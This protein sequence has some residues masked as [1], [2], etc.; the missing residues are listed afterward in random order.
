M[1]RSLS[2]NLF[3]NIVK[4]HLDSEVNYVQRAFN[5]TFCWSNWS[6]Y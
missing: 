3:K 1:K 2:S 5:Y 6:N 4:G